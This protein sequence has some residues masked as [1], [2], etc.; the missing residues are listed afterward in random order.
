MYIDLLPGNGR[1]LEHLRANFE[2]MRAL[3]RSL[4]EEQL[5]YRYAPG[6]WTIKEILV[7]IVDDER[8]YS[9]RALRFARDDTTELP[10]FEQDDYAVAS[11]ADSRQLTSI[12]EEYQAVRRATIALFDGLDDDAFER[13]GTAD[14]NPMSV[15][16]A[17][18]HIAGHELHHLKIIK[19]RYLSR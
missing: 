2:T 3:A 17:A 11:G 7:H 9:Y 12:I 8:I 19:E 18:Y 14:G 5:A 15:R 6:K 10:G 13:Q 1:V 16:A 4:D